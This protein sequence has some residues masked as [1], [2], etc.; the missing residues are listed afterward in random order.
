MVLTAS[1]IFAG[2]FLF[3]PRHGVVPRWWRRKVKGNRIVRENTLKAIYQVLE[4]TGFKSDGVTTAELAKHRHGTLEDTLRDARKISRY[5]L[6]DFD[7][8]RGLMRLTNEGWRQARVIVRN[9]RLWELYLAKSA[10]YQLDHVHDDA[11]RMEHLLGEDTVRELERGLNFPQTDPHG[12]VIP[13]VRES[14]PTKE[15]T[16]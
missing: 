12:R 1:A 6:V 11:E 9:H 8:V 14:A 3:S 2:A 16:P 4:A 7:E 13:S 15:S 10:N 5:K